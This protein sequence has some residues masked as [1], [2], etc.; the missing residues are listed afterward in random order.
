MKVD[1]INTFRLGAD[2]DEVEIEN[3]P[4]ELKGDIPDVVYH[5]TSTKDLESI[6]IYGLYPS[7]GISKFQRG[8]I[9]HQEHS[10][11]TSDFNTAVF[12]ANNATLDKEH[13]RKQE[14]Y[15]IILKLKIPDKNLI[16]PDY[17]AD[18]STTSPRYFPNFGHKNVSKPISTMKSM[19]LSRET[20][21]WSYKGRIPASHILE[22]YYYNEVNNVWIK[23]KPRS[24]RRVL[25]FGHLDR[26]AYKLGMEGG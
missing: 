18:V 20:G 14:T 26:I 12:Y 4:T 3:D 8:G 24:W 9:Y 5:G 16:F 22:V 13:K 11:F 7:K 2:D 23:T 6:L 1:R 17:D 21:K 15:P 19:G 25:K 10:F